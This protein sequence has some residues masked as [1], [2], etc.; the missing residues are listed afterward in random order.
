MPSVPLILPMK[1]LASVSYN[2]FRDGNAYESL[3]THTGVTESPGFQGNK[4]FS[5]G[6]DEAGIP[7]G[8]ARKGISEIGD[9]A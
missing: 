9:R 5:I 6:R 7:M 4:A 1:Y 8:Q 3:R 2:K